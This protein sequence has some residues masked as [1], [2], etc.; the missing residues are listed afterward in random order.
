VS[1]SQTQTPNARLGSLRAL[2][3]VI[4]LGCVVIDYA[5]KQLV[6][7]NIDPA[8]PIPLLGDFLM[9]TL[10]YNSGAAFSMGTGMTVGLAVFACLALL[11]VTIW[12]IPRV[13]YRSWA[14]M[15][16]L[17]WAG[18]AGNL[19]DRLFRPPGPFQG[20]VVD[21]I[22]LKYFAVFNFADICITAAAVLLIWLMLFRPQTA[23]THR[24]APPS[25]VEAPAD[26]AETPAEA[27]TPAGDTETPAEAE[28]TGA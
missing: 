27:E 6:I 5:L 16:G 17:L 18:I 21:F 1:G 12:L 4:A 8:Q 23:P 13:R 7:A 19:A 3:V 22:S 26:D 9:F 25:D 2:V 14:I 24:E 20:E 10:T 11:F 15:T 28:T